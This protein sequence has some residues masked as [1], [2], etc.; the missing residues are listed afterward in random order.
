[1]ETIPS[2]LAVVGILC[3]DEYVNIYAETLR[4]VAW[5]LNRTGCDV[6]RFGCAG[7]LATCTSINSTGARELTNNDRAKICTSCMI[8]QKL[9]S[10]QAVFEANSKRVTEVESAALFINTLQQRLAINNKISDVLDMEYA[11]FKLCR[12]AFF[13]FAMVHKLGVESELVAYT[14]GRFVAG[15]SDLIKL[16]HLF[17]LFQK[18]NRITHLIYVNG[19]YS[20]NSLACQFFNKYGVICL[21][22]EPQLTSQHIL[23]RIL[24]KLHRIELQPEGICSVIDASESSVLRN[25]VACSS[26]FRNFGARIN[27][28]D[29]NAYTSLCEDDISSKEAQDLNQFMK[30]HHRIHSFFLSSEDELIPHV[31]THGFLGDIGNNKLGNYKSQYEFTVYLL[32]EAARKPNIGFIVRIHP[33]MAINKRDM[34]ESAEHRRYRSLLS[35]NEIPRNVLIL[36]GD[37]KISSYFIISI[38]DLVLVSWS[39]IGLEALLLGVSVISVFPSHLMYPITSFSLQ[40]T[41]QEE[42]EQALFCE[43]NF[44]VPQNKKLMNWISFAYEG[45]FFAT[46]AQ[47]N[48]EGTLGRLFRIVYRIFTSIGEY[49]TL[50][51]TIDAIFLRSVKFDYDRLFVKNYKWSNL[52]RSPR[53]PSAKML[54]KYRKRNHALLAEY[55]HKINISK[56]TG[57]S[58]RF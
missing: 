57:R 14:A 45:Q 29:F 31:V 28:G 15:V 38:S 51:W 54:D 18:N 22:V 9:I 23:N 52:I 11:G 2:R 56:E 16:L 4:F 48:R 43:S 26:V 6:I 12:I 25:A 17:E 21:S 42:M 46:A 32:K 20:Q 33:R 7:A 30:G 39:T 27:G 35:E 37:N 24:F 41:T 40:P 1:M 13:D 44:G 8:A 53:D 50:A 3:W 5:K 19:N 10:V 36:Y 47:R 34:F 55:G 49:G 58:P